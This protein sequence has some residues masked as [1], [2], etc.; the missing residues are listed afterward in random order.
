MNAFLELLLIIIL[1]PTAL[2]IVI[3]LSLGIG[4]GIIYL[5]TRWQFWI[6]LICIAVIITGVYKNA[7]YQQQHAAEVAR[8]ERVNRIIERA[9]KWHNTNT[10]W[11][12]NTKTYHGKAQDLVVSFLKFS[13]KGGDMKLFD[14]ENLESLE[15]ALTEVEQGETRTM[16]DT[17]LAS[18][19]ELLT[20]KA[21]LQLEHL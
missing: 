20:G 16:P 7:E 21:Q 10:A 13:E 9:S 14:G 18:P 1:L 2:G 4:I 8:N 11:N 12:F 5:L 6:A 19:E 15:N 17:A 3:R